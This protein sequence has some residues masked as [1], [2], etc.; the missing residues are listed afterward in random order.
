MGAERGRDI[1][2]RSTVTLIYQ[3][4][5]LKSFS[6]SGLQV[7]NSTYSTKL[8]NF[9]NREAEYTAKLTADYETPNFMPS[10]HKDVKDSAHILNG[11]VSYANHFIGE[12]PAEMAG[13]MELSVLRS[14]YDYTNMYKHT[15][16]SPRQVIKN[17][18]VSRYETAHVEHDINLDLSPGQCKNAKMTLSFYKDV[19]IPYDSIAEFCAKSELKEDIKDVNIMK[20]AKATFNDGLKFNFVDEG[21]RCVSF[22]TTGLIKHDILHGVSV[23]LFD[24]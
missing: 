24:C 12:L 1:I 3:S 4:F 18:I 11:T 15:W 17:H 20:L 19:F 10:F 16:Y 9:N 7:I 5:T 14:N 13:G 23:E 8:F 2:D 22:Q 21:E 6:L